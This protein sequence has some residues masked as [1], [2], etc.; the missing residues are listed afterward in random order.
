MFNESGMPNQPGL[1]YNY[2]SGQL[3][4]FN[5]TRTGATASPDQWH[6]VVV[7]S[8]GGEDGVEIYLDNELQ[9]TF[10]NTFAGGHAFGQ[11][12]IGNT[13]LNDHALVGSIDEYAIYDLDPLDG[14]SEKQEKVAAIAGHFALGEGLEIETIEV[15]D[16]GMIRL[17]WKSRPAASYAVTWSPDLVAFSGEV[18]EAVPS[19]GE[20]TEYRFANPTITPGFPEGM[21]RFF[22]RVSEND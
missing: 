15:E 10:T 13:V 1:I 7:A 18:A 22:L 19:Q 2:N 17:V 4:I 20:R 8:Y 3:E 5:G 12:A 11:F 6:H 14:L 21:P 16:G 9:E